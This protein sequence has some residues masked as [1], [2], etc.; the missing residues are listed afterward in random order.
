MSAK[1]KVTLLAL[2]GVVS[3]LLSFF[4]ASQEGSASYLLL[5][6]AFVVLLGAWIAI[7]ASLSGGSGL[8]KYLDYVTST[9]DLTET[10]GIS[11]TELGPVAIKFK[12]FISQLQNK[13][14][15]LD[16]LAVGER[17]VQ[18]ERISAQD[19]LG[20]AVHNLINNL[21]SK[22]KSMQDIA[23]GNLEIEVAQIGS[24]DKMGMAL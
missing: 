18:L 20:E 9:G 2:A 15:V 12:K 1:P 23:H 24:D 3:I 19:S 17:S 14:D 22:I 11:E 10:P 8:D 6:L 16:E 13:V 21:R 5:G 7:N 4:G